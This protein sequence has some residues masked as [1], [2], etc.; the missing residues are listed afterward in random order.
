MF[1]KNSFSSDA[2][3]KNICVSSSLANWMNYTFILG[4]VRYNSDNWLRGR[5]IID[6]QGLMR[7]IARIYKEIFSLNPLSFFIKGV[8]GQIEFFL[9][10]V[11]WYSP[12]VLLAVI[13]FFYFYE[14]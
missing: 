4:W 7:L 14:K 11:S 12:I 6:N 1:E 10:A 5:K 3:F 8:F 9:H 13:Y 2:L